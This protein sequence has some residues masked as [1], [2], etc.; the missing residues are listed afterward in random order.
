MLGSIIGDIV[1]SIY[2]FNNI[3][4]KDFPFFTEKNEFTDDS[5]LSIATADWILHGGQSGKYYADYA[6]RY[7][8]PMGGY[9]TSFKAWAILAAKTGK[10]QAYNSCGNGSAMRICPV[11]WAYE[12]ESETLAAAKASAECTH[13]HPAGIIGAQ[14]VAL[15]IFM[16]RNGKSKDEIRQAM[17][18]KFHYD[19]NFTVEEIKDEYGWNSARFG[20]GGICQASVPQAIVA[21]LDGS[22]FEDCIRNAICIGGDSD[23]IGCI[24]GG[25]AEAFHGIPKDIY[26]KG[27]SYLNA[28]L[29]AVVEKFEEKYGNNMLR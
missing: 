27:I 21:F 22:D 5:I 10:M 26:D 1:G 9:G 12:T 29:R 4:T 16:A 24:T 14:A 11:G 25:M 20:N 7:P 8:Y 18:E 13:N 2:E 19:L 17:S 3:K 6:A 23:T 15:C 28:E